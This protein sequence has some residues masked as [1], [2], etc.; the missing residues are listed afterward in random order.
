MHAIKIGHQ[1]L[2]KNC[3]DIHK[4][5]LS[6]LMNVV[7]S[8]MHGQTLTVTGLGRASRRQTLMKHSIPVNW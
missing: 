2:R 1:L 5:R 3:P 7:E 8:L 4:N 6:A